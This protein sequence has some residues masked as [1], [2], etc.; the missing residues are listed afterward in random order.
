MGL[1]VAPSA[2]GSVIGVCKAYATRVGSGPFPTEL[3]GEEASRWAIEHKRLDEEGLNYDVNDE[4]EL[5]QGIA[6]RTLGREYG[7]TTG[8]LRRCGWLDLPLLKYAIGLNGVTELGITKLDV[9]DTLDE[10]LVCTAYEGTDSVDMN[11]ITNV[12]PIYKKFP[13]WKTSTK[14]CTSYDALPENAKKYLKFIERNAGVPI[15][16]ISTGP[17]RDEMIQK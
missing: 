15:T 3:G 8:R 12:K 14:G 11:N 6:L 9:L 7:A 13:G 17:K 5:H 2:I 4:D 16:L 1:G 10:I